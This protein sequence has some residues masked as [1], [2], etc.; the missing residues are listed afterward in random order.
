MPLLGS[1]L[2][3]GLKLTHLIEQDRKDPYEYQRKELKRLIKTARNTLFGKKYNFGEIL[4]SFSDSDPDK[5]Y[6]FYK[7]RVPVYTYNQIFEE[8]WH[9]SKEGKED[10]CWPGVIKYFALS[11]GT[12]EASTKHIPITKEMLASNKKTSLRQMLSLAN[13][14]IPPSLFGK[15]IL[16]LGGTIDLN[17]V[18]HYYEGDLSG[19]QISKIPRWFLPFYKPGKK[20]AR[21]RDWNMK[22]DEIT[23]KSKDWDIGFVVGV[24]AWIQLMIE[25]VI[26]HHKVSNIHEVWPSL[27]VFVH[28]GV[29]FEPYKNGFEK[30]L[31]HP[32]SYI[33]TYLSSEGFIALQTRPDQAG[34]RMVLNNG[35]FYEFIPFTEENFTTDG[36]LVVNP[37][38]LMIHQ[39]EEGKDYA[40]LLSTNAGTW[41]YLIG[42]VIRFVN[43]SRSEII[44]T[45]RT[46]H[47]LSLCGEHL[48]VENMNKAIS[49][50]AQEFNVELREFAV[51]GVNYQSMFAHKW[52]VA[53]D[54][55]MDKER[56]KARLDER[57][58]EL[59][60]DYRT[61]RIAALKEVFLYVL[62]SSAFYGFMERK[63]KI[64]GQNK[65]PRVL[66]RQLLEEWENYLETEFNIKT[67]IS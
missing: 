7:S 8:W 65:F 28:G 26:E 47:Y 39:V 55:P 5:F 66:K 4:R 14:K 54:E 61:E 17:K 10:V 59:N 63:G 12:S 11:S 52:Y 42:D 16:M 67:K 24:P 29:S 60:D 53:C 6:E 35:L 43:K 27:Q 36:E 1:L 18:D 57:L 50:V 46:K 13:Y 34:M 45:G 33:E 56:L 22:L 48:S 40:L 32:I 64:G 15:G 21:T 31:G 2:S 58:K 25:R 51:A 3:K 9:L 62:P 30:L 19:I 44:I 20:I 41:R 23:F 49:M 37:Q 38:T